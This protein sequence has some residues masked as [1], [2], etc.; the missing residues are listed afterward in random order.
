MD[1]YDGPQPS[2]PPILEFEF[3]ADLTKNKKPDKRLR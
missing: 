2:K 3:N 1:V